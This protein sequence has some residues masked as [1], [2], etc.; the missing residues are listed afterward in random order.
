MFCFV[1]VFYVEEQTF[2]DICGM[3]QPDARGITDAMYLK[4]TKAQQR[5]RMVSR[6]F[7]KVFDMNLGLVQNFSELHERDRRKQSQGMN[8]RLSIRGHSCPVRHWIINLQGVSLKESVFCLYDRRP[9]G[10]RVDSFC[11]DCLTVLSNA[12]AMRVARIKPYEHAQQKLRT[13]W[14]NHWAATHPIRLEPKWLRMKTRAFAKLGSAEP[15][16]CRDPSS[17][18]RQVWVAQEVLGTLEKRWG[19]LAPP[20]L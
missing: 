5:C 18:T 3:T 17:P 16:N 2:G 10:M 1:F 8:L 11:R 14:A 6:Q 19:A 7:P 4:H 13:H 12:K 9:H 20:P 15:P